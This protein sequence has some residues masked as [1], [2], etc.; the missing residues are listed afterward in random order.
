MLPTVLFTATLFLPAALTG[1]PF[2]LTE[3][4]TYVG[5]GRGRHRRGARGRHAARGGVVR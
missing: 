5:P 4:S 2:L 3:L 1:S